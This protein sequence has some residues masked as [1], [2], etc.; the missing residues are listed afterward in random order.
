MI[1]EDLVA[2]E[3][4]EHAHIERFRRA[5][6]LLERAGSRRADRRSSERTGAVHRHRSVHGCRVVRRG[7][8]RIPMRGRDAGDAARAGERRAGARARARRRSRARRPPRRRRAEPD[9][10]LR[11]RRRTRRR[12]RRRSRRPRYRSDR[13]ARRAAG[14]AAT[15]APQAD[16][17]GAAESRRRVPGLPVGSRRSRPTPT[18][19]RSSWRSAKTYLEMGMVD[20]AIGAL[21]GGA[22]AGLSA[23]R[24]RRCSDGC[25]RS[26]T[27]AAARPNGSSAPPRRRRPTRRRGTRAALRSRRDPGD[28]GET[29]RA[30]AVFLELQAEAG[31][32]RDVAAR[33]ERLARVQTGG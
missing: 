9:I 28:S 21:T 4:W 27:T 8:S 2:R 7:A 19:R 23:S 11:P 20:E 29:A 1:A 22:R 32:Y 14:H 17:A 6:V 16:A 3:P 13:R 10:P 15:P 33:V 24:R 5:L 31:E 12:R 30:L 18:K 25:T 26:R